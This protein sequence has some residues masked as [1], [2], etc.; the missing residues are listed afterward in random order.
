MSSPALTK[1][2]KDELHKRLRDWLFDCAT[3]E[4]EYDVIEE[5]SFERKIKLV[6][7]RYDGGLA[8]FLIDAF[9]EIA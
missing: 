9:P 8:Q 6:N 7:K 3:T 1:I 2:A 5:Y 4:E